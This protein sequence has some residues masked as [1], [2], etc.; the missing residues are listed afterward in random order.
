MT[1][2]ADS[3]RH[4]RAS[5]AI[6]ITTGN[7]FRP[8]RSSEFMF[9]AASALRTAMRGVRACTTAA[10]IGCRGSRGRRAGPRTGACSPSRKRCGPN[11]SP[12]ASRPA[13]GSDRA[14][15]LAAPLAGGWAR[16]TRPRAGTWPARRRAPRRPRGGRHDRGPT[17]AAIPSKPR[18]PR[19]PRARRRTVGS[20]PR[21]SPASAAHHHDRCRSARNAP[22]AHTRNSASA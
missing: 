14:T 20:A 22:I 7:A 12:I 13:P 15:P 5:I 8:Y 19:A 11:R 17:P 6:A 9:V 16:T 4:R 1:S 21:G 18:S 10:A 2:T 3:M